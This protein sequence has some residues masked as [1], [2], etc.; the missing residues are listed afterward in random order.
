MQ[1]VSNFSLNFLRGLLH[2]PLIMACWHGPTRSWGLL[3][4]HFTIH[5]NLQHLPF[6]QKYFLEALFIWEGYAPVTSFQIFYAAYW[7]ICLHIYFMYVIQSSTMMLRF[8]YQDY[9]MLLIIFCY[10]I[11]FRP[12]DGKLL[13]QEGSWLCTFFFF[14]CVSKQPYRRIPDHFWPL[15]GH[16][17]I[18]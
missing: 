18:I 9:N 7:L 3:W 16:L 8:A 11:W 15:F 10:R 1:A 4:L 5:F 13:V 14:V 6:C 12:S 17:G 2:L